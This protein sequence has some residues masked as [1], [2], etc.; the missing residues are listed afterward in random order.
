MNREP[1][2][3]RWVALIRA[4]LGVISFG[5]LGWSLTKLVAVGLASIVR[6]VD[7]A[8]SVWLADGRI[9]Q[10]I[11]IDCALLIGFLTA[12][13]IV[14][15]FA[16]RLTAEDLRFRRTG[17]GGRGALVA[18]AAGAV[19]SSLVMLLGVVVGDAS[20]VA[21]AGTP[22]GY[23]G[24]VGLA[25]LVLLPGALAE[26]TMFRGVPLVALDRTIGRGPA[27][28]VTALL[29]ALAHGANPSVTTL[30]IGNICLAGVLL[31]VAF[32][33]P[34]GIWTAMGLHLGWNF[35]LAA[36]D[37]P[38]SGINLR[39]PLIDYLPGQPAW[40]TGG[41]FGPEGGV[42]ATIVLALA[43]A[44]AGKLFLARSQLAPEPPPHSQGST[45]GHT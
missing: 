41:P 33:A 4:I 32:F 2:F 31:G 26:E 27:I 10:I 23:A 20:W 15:R 45:P 6:G 35:G 36:L 7:G 1:A 17:G 11:F 25:F 14:G 9:E 5:L 3:P 24:R 8:D 38:V 39:I 18:F 40:L 43:T 30:S 16:L 22:S 28:G 13:V 29:F 37:A 21:D 42:L 44:M 34:G 19:L 12:T